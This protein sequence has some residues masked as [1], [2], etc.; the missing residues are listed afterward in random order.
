[1]ICVFELVD[2]NVLDLLIEAL[3]PIHLV[4]SALG[5][6]AIHLK[7]IVLLSSELLFQG[8]DAVV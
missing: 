8:V 1:M 3:T 5:D 2:N 7:N 4:V 6:L